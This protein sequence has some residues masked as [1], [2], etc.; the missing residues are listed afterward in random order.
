ML[1]FASSFTFPKFLK[2][3]I[4]TLQLLLKIFCISNTVS[5][6]CWSK[7]V[8]T[9]CTEWFAFCLSPEQQQFFRGY[10]SRSFPPVH[11][12]NNVSPFACLPAGRFTSFESNR[13]AV[14]F[15][16]SIDHILFCRPIVCLSET[17]LSSAD[18]PT[19]RAVL[20][21]MPAGAVRRSG[22]PSGRLSNQ[23]GGWTPSRRT[24]W[25]DDQL[26]FFT[27]LAISLSSFYDNDL[28]SFCLFQPSSNC[29]IECV[30]ARENLS[31]VCQIMR[32]SCINMTCCHE[33]VV[34]RIRQFLF[35]ARKQQYCN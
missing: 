16:Q 21:L 29:V 11:H 3:N 5:I 12:T 31:I 35:P 14:N 8:Y 18:R 2:V 7:P 23:P 32:F 13:S 17:T 24:W 34:L 6:S 19:D 22:R 27:D 10:R 4:D 25:Y 20:C 33:A 1:Q 30:Y 9:P 26:H 15:S 28:I